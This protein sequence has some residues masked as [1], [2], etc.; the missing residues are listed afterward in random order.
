MFA[1]ECQ[2]GRKLAVLW[3]GEIFLEKKTVVLSQQG[4][5][6]YFKISFHPST[7][8]TGQN[9]AGSR[10]P[11]RMFFLAESASPRVTPAARETQPWLGLRR[12]GG[13]TRPTRLHGTSKRCDSTLAWRLAKGPRN[14]GLFRGM[15]VMPRSNK[16][17]LGSMCRAWRQKGTFGWVIHRSLF[18]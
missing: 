7:C 3:Q 8:P 9:K 4:Q 16:S 12:E 15:E 11:I 17:E 1:C 13:S 2:Y 18:N 10:P 6:G 14:A 5:V